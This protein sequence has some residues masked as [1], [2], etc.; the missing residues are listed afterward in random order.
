MFEVY[1]LTYPNL[2]E[3]RRRLSTTEA[4]REIKRIESDLAASGAK[5]QYDY[6]YAGAELIDD[7]NI[8]EGD[9]DPFSDKIPD[10]ID[11]DSEDVR[12]KTAET[13][14]QHTL[15]SIAELVRHY[16]CTIRQ[17]RSAPLFPPSQ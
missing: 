7:T 4:E 9:D 13:V 16:R 1:L 14:N 11:L 15:I 8:E 10:T 5:D 17:L 2:L 3:K 12:R 6:F